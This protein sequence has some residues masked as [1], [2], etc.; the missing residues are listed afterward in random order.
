MTALLGSEKI[1]AFDTVG[2][3]KFENY[4]PEPVVTRMTA[5]A[6]RWVQA[7]RKTVQTT[8]DS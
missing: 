5:A 7:S 4:V 3:L 6:E 1:D 8:N 2:F